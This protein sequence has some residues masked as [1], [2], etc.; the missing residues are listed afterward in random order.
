MRPPFQSGL[1]AR[2]SKNVPFSAL[3][4][5]ASTL[6]RSWERRAPSPGA[7]DVRVRR[8]RAPP[9]RSHG[10]NAPSSTSWHSSAPGG[11]ELYLATDASA[12]LALY[13]CR[14]GRPTFL[15]RRADTPRSR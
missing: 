15:Y 6:G 3:L 12:T 14:D 4:P 10:P 13:T 2:A 7:R 11:M 5:I 9:R 8:L 1:Y